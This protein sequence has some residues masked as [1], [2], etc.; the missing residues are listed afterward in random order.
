M[1][2]NLKYQ[3]IAKSRDIKKLKTVQ[4]PIKKT[5]ILYKA[6]EEVC[7]LL[8]PEQQKILQ[9]L[10]KILRKIEKIRNVFMFRVPKHTAHKMLIKRNYNLQKT[11]VDF[12]KVNS[13]NMKQKT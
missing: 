3:K 8:R 10:S 4:L 12:K 9:K 1:E 11:F 5:V 13:R 2:K 6:L 7:W